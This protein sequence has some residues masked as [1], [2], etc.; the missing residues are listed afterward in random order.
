MPRL[1]ERFGV[2]RFDADEQY[3]Q[4]LAYYQKSQLNEAILAMEKAIELLPKNSEYYAARGFF[5][6]E[7]GTNK[8]ALADFTRALQLYPYEVLALYGQGVIAYKAK[9][10]DEAITHFTEAYR[11]DPQRPETLY[12]L[13]LSQHHNSQNDLALAAMRQASALFAAAGDKRQAD[14]ER[15]VRQLEKIITQP[16]T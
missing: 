13:A 15:W 4:A 2:A 5:Y 7:D 6:L 8:K 16:P 14:A 11:A 1:T 3:K 10:W 12:Y 9:K